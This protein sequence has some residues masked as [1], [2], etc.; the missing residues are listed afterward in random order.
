MP[1]KRKPMTQDKNI[2]IRIDERLKDKVQKAA[3]K[4]GLSLS[5]YIRQI[6]KEKVENT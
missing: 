3:Y 4:A 2:I 5:D 6:L 1:Q